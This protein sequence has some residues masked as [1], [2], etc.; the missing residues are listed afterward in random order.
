M[1][2]R[3]LEPEVMDDPR[4]ADDYDRM[5]HGEVNQRFVADLL[6]ST[7]PVAAWRT[8]QAQVLDLGTGT[9][10]IPIELC[11]Q[12]A[13]VRVLGVDLAEGMLALGRLHVREADFTRRIRLARADAKQLPYADGEFGLVMSNSIVHHLPEP[14]RA[15]EE[16][17][18][19][20]QDGGSIFIRD[21]LRPA[22]ESE[23]ERLVETHAVAA[24]SRQRQLFADS[25]RAA[26]SLEEI[27]EL[28]AGLSFDPSGVSPTSDR[29]WTWCTAK[30]A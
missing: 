15:L 4:D 30:P 11:R 20:C 27:R 1:L 26:L 14:R 9:G 18:R 7:S 24:E 12:A 5:D 17:A 25:L 21:L 16:A 10:L 2:A 22:N 28:V 19:V 29:H 13:H 3:V 8:G 6:A 23:L